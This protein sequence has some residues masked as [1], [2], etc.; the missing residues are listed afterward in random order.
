M[1]TLGS[2]AN[3]LPVYA[4][5]DS[6]VSTFADRVYRAPSGT[7]YL[8]RAL[9]CPGLRAR[10]FAAPGGGLGPRITAALAAERLLVSH[11]ATLEP[12]HAT[13]STHWA[14]VRDLEGRAAS[15]PPLA[16]AA[17]IIDLH[18]VSVGIA[19]PDIELPNVLRADPATP[20]VCLPTA[21]GALP[22]ADA[23]RRY[24]DV[25]EPLRTGL[26]ALRALGF[27]RL[28]V[29][30]LPPVTLD[31]AYADRAAAGAGF[32]IVPRPFPT[33]F[34]YKGLLIA[35][36]VFARLSREE[37]VTFVDR[38]AAFTGAD[39]LVAPGVLRDFIH[40]TPEA[41]T[42]SAAAL[43]AEVV[44]KDRRI[45][46]DAARDAGDPADVPE[47]EDA[48]DAPAFQTALTD[49]HL[50]AVHALA[51]ASPGDRVLHVGRGHADLPYALAANGAHVTA[52]AYGPQAAAYVH[53][54]VRLAEPGAAFGDAPYDV[55]IT[56]GVDELAPG[57]ADGLYRALAGALRPSGLLIVHPARTPWAARTGGAETPLPHASPGRLRR[58]LRAAFP[59]VLVWLGEGDDVR[60][61][62]ARPF[63]TAAARSATDVFAVASH[64]PLDASALLARITT[65]PLDADESQVRLTD[66]YAP[67][68]VVRGQRFVAEVTLHNGG[69]APLSSFGP[70]PVQFA[71]VWLDGE[72]RPVDGDGARALVAPA[73]RPCETGRYAVQ[74][75][76]PDAPGR[77][78]LRLTLV[79]EFVRWY[80]TAA[81]LVVAVL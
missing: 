8:F 69:D 31:D 16:I 55:A 61:S 80:S 41:T 4:L 1:S 51:A 35:N 11:G 59:H 62:L 21:A 66:A 48:G 38:W 64:Q 27:T 53:P 74:V 23:V 6:N 44:E 54:R 5:G 7:S 32:A 2:P 14:W 17:G 46:A 52:T 72:H 60:G 71:A 29:L 58:E 18:E 67:R 77:Y 68:R 81:D 73:A 25:L 34:R 15:P 42:R 75:T 13:T 37:N 78:T 45:V 56:S 9:Y 65:E 33:A 43:V 47:T 50:A 70:N 20:P 28:G 36:M 3:P 57:E 22:A 24:A 40:L 76:A 49:V 19:E 39:G 10:D 26:R 63:T 30:G 12:A 79:Q